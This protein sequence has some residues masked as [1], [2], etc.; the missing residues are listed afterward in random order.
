M[1]DH[2]VGFF[3]LADE[4]PTINRKKFIAFCEELIARNLGILWGINTRV[5][6]ILRDE[7]VLPLYLSET[8]AVRVRRAR[9]QF[10]A[11][12]GTYPTHL[13]VD[14]SAAPAASPSILFYVIGLV[15]RPVTLIVAIRV[16]IRV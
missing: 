11:L 8:Q 12:A 14:Q 9:L 4:E 1:R 5:T 13:T 6:D 7:D 10:L 2:D 3:I 16:A 15:V